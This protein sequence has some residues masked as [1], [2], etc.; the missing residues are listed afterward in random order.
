MLCPHTHAV[1]F[2]PKQGR[3]AGLSEGYSRRCCIACGLTD[4]A[5]ERWNPDSFDETSPLC[6][7]E[8]VETFDQGYRFNHF[9]LPSITTYEPGHTDARYDALISGATVLGPDGTS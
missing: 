2:N 6:G 1:Q 8:I 4:T 9:T 3:F 5:E 7:A